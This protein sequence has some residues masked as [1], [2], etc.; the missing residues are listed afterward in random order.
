MRVHD[1]IHSVAQ[2]AYAHGAAGGAV[3]AA[4]VGWLPSIAGVLGIAWYGVLFYDR[5]LGKG[6]RN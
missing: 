1:A 4:I 6:K 3:L 2:N 5:F